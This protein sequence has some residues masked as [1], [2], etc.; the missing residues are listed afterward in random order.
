MIYPGLGEGRF[1]NGHVHEGCER[2]GWFLPSWVTDGGRRLTPR[3]SRDERRDPHGRETRCHRGTRDRARGSPGLE[4][5]YGSTR[6]KLVR[7]PMSIGMK[8][9]GRECAPASQNAGWGT[10]NR[11]RR[12]LVGD[13]GEA[14]HRRTPA[15]RPR[16]PLQGHPSVWSGGR[17]GWEIE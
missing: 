14:N 11:L 7:S 13:A 6:Y 2:I 10:A 9:G 5:V 17:G 12:T 15:D 3:I 8:C 4:R 1:V 16:H